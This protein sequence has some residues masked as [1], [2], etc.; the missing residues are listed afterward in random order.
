MAPTVQDP[1]TYVQTLRASP[2]PGSP[3]SLAIP[4]SAREGR[5]GIYRHYKF[6]DKPLLQTID[7][8][9]LT[10]HDFFEKSARKWPNARCLGHRAWDP[11]TKTYGNYQ[12]IT[13]AETAERR[14]N[15]GVGLAELHKRAGITDNK[16]GVGLWCQNRPEWQIV[17]KRSRTIATRIALC[18][19][20]MRYRFGGNVTINLHGLHLRYSRAGYNRVYHQPCYTCLCLYELTTYPYFVEVGA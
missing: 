13:Y 2:P 10:S 3:Y 12:W 15:F 1:D 5:S 11:A 17:G 4:G 18:G 19:S 6:V 16:Y 8:E 20:D 9:C 7:T 14:K